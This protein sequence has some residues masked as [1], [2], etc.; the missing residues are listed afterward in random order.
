MIPV[1]KLVLVSCS[2]KCINSLILEHHGVH[3]PAL[4]NY[5]ASHC[6]TTPLSCSKITEGF[7]HLGL[8]ASTGYVDDDISTGLY[9][10]T[11]LGSKCSYERRGIGKQASLWQKYQRKSIVFQAQFLF[12]CKNLIITKICCL[13]YTVAYN[14]KPTSPPVSMVSD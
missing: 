11:E 2:L 7:G 4:W 8:T 6:L 9:G 1:P 12:L 13:W 14:Y 3:Y 10:S 5:S